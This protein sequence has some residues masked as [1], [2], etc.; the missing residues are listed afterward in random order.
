MPTETRCNPFSA[1]GATWVAQVLID[2]E[3][4]NEYWSSW[5]YGLIWDLI[6]QSREGESLQAVLAAVHE[7]AGRRGGED[8]PVFLA[9]DYIEAFGLHH[10]ADFVEAADGYDE[11]RNRL[12]RIDGQGNPG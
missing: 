7:S 1:L 4:A 3:T 12:T 10:L 9:E 2:K 6:L 11:L 5:A 8:G